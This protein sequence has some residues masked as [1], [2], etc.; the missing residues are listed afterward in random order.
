MYQKYF[1]TFADS[2][3]AKSLAR[4]KRQ[5]EDAKYFDHIY[6]NNES[7][8]DADFREF[9]KDKLIKGT[10]GYGYW[11]WK[12]QIILQ[13]LKQMQDGDVLLYMDVGCHFNKN[14]L[15][16][17]D[18][19][20]NKTKSSPSGLLVF[21]EAIK[22]E[23]RNLE[24]FYRNLEKIY[25]KGDIFDYFNVRDREDI[26]NTGIIAATSF[27]VKKCKE[28]QTIIE[29]WLNTFKSRFNLVDNSPSRSSNFDGFIENRHDQSIFSMLCKLNNIESISAY[30]MW[31]SDWNKL[32]KYPILAKRDKDLGL[33]W[34]IHRKVKSIINKYITI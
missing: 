28:S 24:T 13:T 32:G 14:G 30:E 33:Y 8:L 2:R 12:P 19:Y 6:I 27:L 11:V 3:M 22:A 5:V 9:F 1:C 7:N 23:D 25:T 29:Q 18:Y 34:R 26:Y 21:Q 17:M 15:E 16:R 20:F 4:V 10:R 31:Q